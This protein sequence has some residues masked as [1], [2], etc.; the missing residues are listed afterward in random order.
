[1]T[2]STASCNFS[3]FPFFLKAS[4]EL[5]TCELIS[6]GNTPPDVPPDH[7]SSRSPPTPLSRQPCPTCCL[8]RLSRESRL[9]RL[10]LVS[11]Y[12]LVTPIDL[13]LP[14]VLNYWWEEAFDHFFLRLLT[15]D[16]KLK[17]V[18]HKY[19]SGQYSTC[20]VTLLV[21]C[22]GASVFPSIIDLHHFVKMGV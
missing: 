21:A 7:R 13:L 12:W 22:V 16:A 14:D 8:S 9:S 18:K 6:N 2:S 11:I 19:F 17:S 20:R 4:D 1:M 5:T 15:I 10:G 3:Y